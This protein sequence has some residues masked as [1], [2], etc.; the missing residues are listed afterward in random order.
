MPYE[1]WKGRPTLVRHLR[2]FGSKCYIKR[3]EEHLS[4]FDSKNYE[5]IFLDFSMTSNSYRCYNKR[6]KR[7]VKIFNVSV[8]ETMQSIEVINEDDNDDLSHN[9]DEST[10]S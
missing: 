2:I 1:L 5:R 10:R 3:D 6:L 9:G 7:I 4:K 8:D